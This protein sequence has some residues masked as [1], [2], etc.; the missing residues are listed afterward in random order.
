MAPRGR[1]KKR[2][3]TRMDAAVDAM[4]RF[5]FQKQRVRETVKELLKVYGGDDGWPFIE[6][7][8]YVI[9]LDA[10][11]ETQKSDSPKKDVSQ[12]DA[13]SLKDTEPSIVGSPSGVTTPN[14]SELQTLNANLPSDGA[15]YSIKDPEPVT[16]GSSC[17]VPIPDCSELETL[18]TKLPSDTTTNSILQSTKALDFEAQTN[19]A[20]DSSSTKQDEGAS[21]ADEKLNLNS[22]TKNVDNLLDFKIETDKRHIVCAKDSGDN[23]NVAN[24]APIHTPNQEC[25]LS[26][27][28]RRRYHGWISASCE[29]HNDNDLVDLTPIP[30]P[31]GLARLFR[32]IH[33]EEK[34]KSSWDVRPEDMPQALTNSLRA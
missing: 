12:D 26:L 18:H 15:L 17:G 30:L 9:L 27:R 31:E 13:R 10:L 2:G 20:D 21:L 7:D 1:S 33:G 8:S 22:T 5:G 4:G 16:A 23:K 25:S 34:R 11:L 28:K 14:F 6:D 19:E 3:N 24:T 29:D 32:K